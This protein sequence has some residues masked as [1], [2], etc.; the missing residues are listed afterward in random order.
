[1][2]PLLKWTNNFTLTFIVNHPSINVI[3]IFSNNF[4]VCKTLKLYMLIKQLRTEENETITRNKETEN[5][6]KRTCLASCTLV[7]LCTSSHFL[8]YLTLKESI[9]ATILMN[10]L[11]HGQLKV[12]ILHPL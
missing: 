11:L 10:S 12:Y 9:S 8:K 7:R 2:L 6:T 1:M 4:D 5:A 3:N